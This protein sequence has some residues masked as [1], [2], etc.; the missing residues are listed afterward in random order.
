MLQWAVKKLRSRLMMLRLFQLIS[1]SIRRGQSSYEDHC[2]GLIWFLVCISTFLFAEAGKWKIAAPPSTNACT[3]LE[4]WRKS[5]W[6]EGRGKKGGIENQQV[7]PSAETCCSSAQRQKN[8][9]IN[10]RN[11]TVQLPFSAHF[12][13]FSTSISCVVH[14]LA[15]AAQLSTGSNPRSDIYL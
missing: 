12:L 4:A 14:L 15:G 9:A 6:R 8:C 13:H 10:Q 2:D 3:T 1:E 7:L 11:R 5:I